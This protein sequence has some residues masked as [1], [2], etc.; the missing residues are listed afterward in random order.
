MLR[1]P[2]IIVEG[3]PIGIETKRRLVERLTRAASEEYGISSITV[4]IK[5][6]AAENV[7][8]DGALLHDKRRKKK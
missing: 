2:T 5:E 1:M 3:P 4:L 7:G 6:N 8:I